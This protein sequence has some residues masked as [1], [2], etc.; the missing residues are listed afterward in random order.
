MKNFPKNG[1]DYTQS[2][3]IY[4]TLTTKIDVTFTTKQLKSLDDNVQKCLSLLKNIKYYLRTEFTNKKLMFC[5][6][7]YHG[8]LYIENES[9]QYFSDFIQKWKQTFNVDQIDIQFIENEDQEKKV[10]EYINKFKH[11]YKNYKHIDIKLC[12]QN[13]HNK[14]NC[15][16]K[17]VA[18]D[19]MRKEA[20]ECNDRA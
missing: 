12:N 13:I 6:I 8:I 3:K 20:E 7:H 10:I 11:L 19:A 16:M 1:I 5:K 15:L 2:F 17:I 4:V 9:S 14:V 18:S